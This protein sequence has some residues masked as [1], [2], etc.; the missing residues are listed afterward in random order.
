MK[1]MR[2]RSVTPLRARATI[3]GS[4]K[5]KLNDWKGDT[6]MRVPFLYLKR[7]IDMKKFFA[8][9]TIA[10]GSMMLP[11]CASGDLNLARLLSAGVKA[12][13]A[14]TITD[15]QVAAYVSQYIKYMDRQN[16][17]LPAN[18]KYSQRLAKLTVKFKKVNGM[19]LNFK[20]YQTS[21]LNAFAAAD[22]SVR[23]YTGLMDV[24][25]DDE[26][27]GV[28]GHE[29][30]HVANHDSKKAFKQALL[31]SA[32]RDGIGAGDGWM[33]ALTNSQ[34]G[35][36]GEA[37]LGAKYSRKQETAADNYAYNFLKRNGYNPWALASA[38]EKMDR[39]AQ[40]SGA[41]SSALT[42]LFSSH[43]DMQKRIANIQSRC[44]KDGI[45]RPAKK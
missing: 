9:T 6:L 29:I 33:A 24:M 17:V 40:K 19:P 30:G 26:L 36:L 42:Q 4:H 21:E 38:F 27:R 8:V 7:M 13:Q 34:L 1:V 16:K 35:D 43:P 32:L 22:G 39:I 25:T 41:R 37:M 3:Y 28:I 10:I 15:S 45:A 12:T 2:T 20:V 5:K 44:K 18:N 11:S 14:A 23:V 31:T